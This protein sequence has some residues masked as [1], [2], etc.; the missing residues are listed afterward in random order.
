MKRNGDGG[1]VLQECSVSSSWRDGQRLGRRAVCV[2]DNLLCGSA[3]V[4]NNSN[5]HFWYS[6]AAICAVQRMQCLRD[7]RVVIRVGTDHKRGSKTGLLQVAVQMAC[8]VGGR[9]RCH[10]V[11]AWIS[12]RRRDSKPVLASLWFCDNRDRPSLGPAAAAPPIGSLSDPGENFRRGALMA[13]IKKNPSKGVQC[14]W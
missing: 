12:G 7:V 2:V 5:H 14:Q 4:N 1:L 6:S 3:S 8:G 13:R 11:L 10:I 9:A